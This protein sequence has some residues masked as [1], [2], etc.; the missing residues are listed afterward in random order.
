MLDSGLARLCQVETFNVNKAVKRNLNRFPE[1]FMFQLSQEE[2]RSLR[3]QLGMSK[4]GGG[5]GAG[6]IC[7]PPLPSTT[8]PC[9]LPQGPAGRRGHKYETG[10]YASKCL[11]LFAAQDV[12]GVC[13]EE[14]GRSP[15]SRRNLGADAPDSHFPSGASLVPHVAQSPYEIGALSGSGNLGKA[16]SAPDSD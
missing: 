5:R 4:P 12:S 13:Q 10:D 16:H 7:P 9:C 6:A 1:D 15:V 11:G 2:A 3:F 14:P 8:R